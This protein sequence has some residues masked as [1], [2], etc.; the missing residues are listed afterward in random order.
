MENNS[1]LDN[2]ILSLYREQ[3]LVEA[4]QYV[5][6]TQKWGLKESKDYVDKVIGRLKESQKNETA[7]NLD[8]T[9]IQLCKTGKKIHAVKLVMEQT[10]WGLKESKDY[11]EHL[12][13]KWL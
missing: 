10:G 2:L 5:M 3:K 12:E 13:R 7:K 8:E 6:R 1:E 11:V 9:V 4:I